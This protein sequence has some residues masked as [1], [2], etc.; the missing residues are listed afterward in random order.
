[1][2]RVTAT[3]TSSGSAIF[4]GVFERSSIPQLARHNMSSDS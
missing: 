2:N 1:M 4:A 3:G